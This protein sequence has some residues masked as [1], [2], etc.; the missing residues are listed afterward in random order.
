MIHNIRV[1]V[2]VIDP[3]SYDTMSFEHVN[4]MSESRKKRRA[5]PEIET[6]IVVK[7]L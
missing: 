2:S 3:K 5:R 6:I 4:R 1:D 7:K